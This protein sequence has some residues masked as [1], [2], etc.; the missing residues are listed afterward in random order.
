MK[1]YTLKRKQFL[2]I[3]LEDAW[4]FFSAP[5]NLARITPSSM[6]FHILSEDAD[7]PIFAGKVICYKVSPLAGIPMTWMTEITQVEEGRYFVDEQ[8]AGPYRIW[9]HLH[10]F[11]ETEGGVIMEDL[12]HYALPAGILGRMM[13]ALLVGRKLRQI[14]DY[15][16]EVLSRMFPLKSEAA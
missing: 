12:V 15:R 5:K 16:R 11:R 3:S 14:F 13:H 7:S 2:P 6:G 8:K 1:I 10:R 4:E 9:H